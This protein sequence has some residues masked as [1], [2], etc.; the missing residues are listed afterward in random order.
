MSDLLD[1]MGVGFVGVWIIVGAFI[2][3]KHDAYHFGVAIEHIR[4]LHAGGRVFKATDAWDLRPYAVQRRVRVQVCAAEL[5]D[6][7]A[8]IR[9][10]ANLLCSDT[11]VEGNVVV[12]V[13]R[14]I[15]RDHG[16]V[17]V[18]RVDV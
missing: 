2:H 18:R 3:E 10:G 6:E 17:L 16:P 9:M 12:F 14:V 15:I 8:E 11:V 7:M 5:V 1:G 4:F 13:G